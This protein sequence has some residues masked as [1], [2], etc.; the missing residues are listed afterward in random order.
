MDNLIKSMKIGG[1]AFLDEDYWHS[2]DNES[3]NKKGE[4]SKHGGIILNYKNVFTSTDDEANDVLVSGAK[5]SL[6]R[7][8]LYDLIEDAKKATTQ[9][10]KD[11]QQ[12]KFDIKPT[13]LKISAFNPTTL[14]CRYCQ[15]SNICYV[16]RATDAENYN[17]LIIKH[18]NPP[19]KKII[20]KENEGNKE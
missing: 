12:L 9:T 14:M 5:F 3:F 8:N 19:K 20:V 18:F 17:P 7:Y 1:S 2:I 10:I 16:K 15:Y 11:I 13:S 6:E 4:I